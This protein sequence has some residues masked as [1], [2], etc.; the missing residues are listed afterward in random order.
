[1]TITEVKKLFLD[2]AAHWPHSPIPQ[3]AER[4]WLVLLDD[5]SY[6]EA[7]AAVDRIAASG[8]KFPPVAG[9]VR[10]AIFADESQ[11][12]R[13][14]RHTRQII[15]LA[16]AGKDPELERINWWIEEYPEMK[17]HIPDKYLTPTR[18]D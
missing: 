9:E 4:S 3:H 14:R 18:K 7:L 16:E 11:D 12:A 1:M 6:D 8:R 5:F 2:C 13:L 15:A 10:N 17:P